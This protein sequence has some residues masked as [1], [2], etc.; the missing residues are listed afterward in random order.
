ERSV[1]LATLAAEPIVINELAIGYGEF[2]LSLFADLGMRPNI[3]AVADNIDTLKA[4]VQSGKGIAIV[5]RACA[6]NEVALGLLTS[7]RIT[8]CGKV[9]FSLSRRRQPEPRKK[10]AH[11][12]AL[13][14]AQK[15]VWAATPPDSAG[16]RRN[17]V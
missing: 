12:G 14:R 9:F 2:V 11:L 17:R 10:E 4:I 1:P 16:N 3:L 13:G 7:T 5:P 8:P 6:R 15:S